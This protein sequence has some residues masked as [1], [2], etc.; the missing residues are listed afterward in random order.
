[1]KKLLSFSIVAM[2][3]FGFVACKKNSGNNSGT[4]PFGSTKTDPVTPPVA[5]DP[6]DPVGP[7]PIDYT[8]KAILEEFTGE[9]CGWCPEGAEVM[10][11]AIAANPE[12]VI[13]IAVHDGD[14]MEIPSF[15]SWIKALTKVAGF[16][17]GSVDRADASDRGSWMGQLNT[18]MAKPTDVGIA[19]VTK[20]NGTSQDITVYIGYK[21]S[22]SGASLTVVLTED[23][24][25]Q[26]SPGAQHNYSAQVVVDPNTWTH[27]HVLRGIVTAN[28]GDPVDLTSP[29]G[30][31]IVE[32][33]DVDI[34]SMNI[35]DMANVEIAAFIN[36]NT[37]PRQ[38]YNA[39]KAGL[40][41]VKKW[42]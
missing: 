17:N 40:T 1:M 23:K 19:M 4:S 41:E 8:H 24:V 25:P 31:T 7:L 36:D 18:E 15:N 14:P 42:D 37:T 32:F 35:K 28:A 27:S 34:S 22:I 10:K 20:N 33:K 5:A 6:L 3:M 29:K 16:P 26:S 11:Q 21:K 38:V 9:W 30:Y 12:K 39:Q 2:L 13:G